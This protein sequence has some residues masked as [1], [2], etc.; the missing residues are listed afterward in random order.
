M[1]RSSSHATSA[2]IGGDATYNFNFDIEWITGT[3]IIDV[4]DNM[5]AYV[6]DKSDNR[7][8]IKMTKLP[9]DGNLSL[10]LKT[11]PTSA[12]YVSPESDGIVCALT[13]LQIPDEKVENYKKEYIFFLDRSGSMEG[14]RI[15]SAK[16]GL[17]MILDEMMAN[18]HHNES[19]FNIIGFGY[20]YESMFPTSLQATPE[21]LKIAQKMLQ[22]WNANMG[23]TEI[24]RP[25]Q[26]IQTVK[27]PSGSTERLIILLTDGEVENTEAVVNYIGSMKNTRT[28]TIGIGSDVNRNLVDKCADAGN[29]LSV[30]VADVVNLPEK[31]KEM[32]DVCA[33][34][35]YTN[36][37]TKYYDSE[38]IALNQLLSVQHTD[39]LY[40]NKYFM[41][42]SSF[43]AED[44]KKIKKVSIFGIKQD[45][46]YEKTNWNV[47]IDNASEATIIDELFQIF[48]KEAINLDLFKDE[49]KI[50]MCIKHTVLCDLVSMIA[51]DHDSTS[52]PEIGVNAMVPNHSN[53]YDD[54]LL[55]SFSSPS[56]PPPAAS[57][58][59][60]AA[61]AA[62]GAGAKC[63]ESDSEESVAG[64]GGGLFGG[65][66]Q[67]TITED[68][69]RLRSLVPADFDFNAV[70]QKYISANPL[71][72]FITSSG[73]THKKQALQT[74]AITKDHIIKL[75][76]CK[77][78]IY[79]D[80]IDYLVTHEEE[81][82][83]VII[84]YLKNVNPDEMLLK[85][86]YYYLGKKTTSVYCDDDDDW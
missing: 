86:I 76:K 58:S 32:L 3:K 29:G 62:G 9:T 27:S 2:S 26:Y 38:G 53:M 10:T 79:D 52:L 11:E 47:D 48:V 84:D 24:L 71:S 73:I 69:K 15:E 61:C 5:S 43:K 8:N 36:I 75:L 63:E 66:Y 25:L 64:G 1:F 22:H 31:I 4:I 21:H 20:E 42:I 37:V 60:Y 54:I 57:Y 18:K 81:F 30:C 13:S 19:F 34:L 85:K 7:C 23:G 40:P 49:E 39:T 6:F 78:E 74:I 59:T 33:K 44:F 82:Y 72:V 45:N 14:K 28:F 68:D 17:T 70:N 67:E 56:H 55:C 41:N 51:V 83:K 35:Y 46:T 77:S 12:F 80:F 65:S 50:D 16:K